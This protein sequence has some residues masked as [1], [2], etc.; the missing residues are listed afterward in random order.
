MSKDT[1]H[2]HT[3]DS[4]PTSPHVPKGIRILPNVWP[5]DALRVQPGDATQFV[6]MGCCFGGPVIMR[7]WDTL[8]G[9]LAAGDYYSGRAH[10]FHPLHGAPLTEASGGVLYFD[11]TADVPD[12][13]AAL[14][15]M[16]APVR[17]SEYAVF[18]SES[19]DPQRDGYLTHLRLMPLGAVGHFFGAKLDLIP[20][21]RQPQPMLLGSLI[22]EFIR[23]AVERWGTGM[24]PDLYGCMGGDGDWAKEALCF[25]LMMENEYH[26]ICRL[27][28]RAW[29]VTK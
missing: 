24:C 21:A 4:L 25:G 1:H 16:H 12:V 14:R 15:L 26:G 28:T 5:G 2:P 22:S 29:L 27:W 8:E 18:L 3:P 19:S 9:A 13:M 7:P 10:S 23:L 17:A 20:D 11:S 6:P